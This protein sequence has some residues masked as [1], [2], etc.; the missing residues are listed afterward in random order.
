VVGVR[1]FREIRFLLLDP[2]AVLDEIKLDENLIEIQILALHDDD[3]EP[4]GAW[5][6]VQRDEQLGPVEVGA[7]YAYDVAPN[8]VG[9]GQVDVGY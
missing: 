3:R 5:Q 4:L 2:L 1:L 9:L 7:L 8:F 6:E